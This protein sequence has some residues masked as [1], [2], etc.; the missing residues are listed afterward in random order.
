M[1]V[2]SGRAAFRYAIDRELGGPGWSPGRRYDE[3]VLARRCRN[4]FWNA[5]APIC[6]TTVG[7][8]P[9]SNVDAIHKPFAF[10]IIITD[11]L[12]YANNLINLSYWGGANYLVRLFTT[13]DA[14]GVDYFGSANFTDQVHTLTHYRNSF[15]PTIV[16]GPSNKMHFNPY[17]L[18]PSQ[19]IKVSWRVIGG[20]I[21]PL[22]TQIC[23]EADYRGV[24]V[25]PENDPYATLCGRLKQAVC[26]Q[27]GAHEPET[28]ILDVTVPVGGPQPGQEFT[29]EPQQRPLLIY[30]IGTN[31]SGVQC[32]LRDLS[33][34]WQFCSTGDKPLVANDTGVFIPSLAPDMDG[35]PLY[36]VANNPEITNRDAYHMLAVP[37]L[38][39][40]LATLS[41]RLTPGLRPRA[42]T[43]AFQQTYNTNG[44]F[45]AGNGVGRISLLCRTV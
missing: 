26:E 8:F 45:N 36:V 23:H 5:Q 44:L 31:I 38:L 28:V 33:T 37:H 40:P 29:T 10:P 13:E 2:T 4:I 1:T 24:T 18:K 17:L 42:D 11:I 27:I 3:A 35:I 6:L 30:G 14:S 25:L 39:E 7:V 19:V 20:W 41:F 21:L 15:S 9:T 32:K 16:D 22:T 12:N 34:Q 43:G